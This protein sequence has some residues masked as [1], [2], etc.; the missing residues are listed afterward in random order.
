M[1]TFLLISLILITTCNNSKKQV[2]DD[3]ALYF[4]ASNKNK[5]RKYYSHKDGPIKY[6]YKIKQINNI[7]FTPKME[8][9]KREKISKKDMINLNING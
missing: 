2:L 6:L 3:D 7:V 8:N 4:Y 1:K 5:M 9:P